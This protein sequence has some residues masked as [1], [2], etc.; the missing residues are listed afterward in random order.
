MTRLSEESLRY[1]EKR[2]AFSR[3][4]ETPFERILMVGA[5]ASIWSLHVGF[6]TIGALTLAAVAFSIL[7]FPAFVWAFRVARKNVKYVSGLMGPNK[8]VFN[9]AFTVATSLGILGANIGMIANRYVVAEIQEVLSAR[10]TYTGRVVGPKVWGWDAELE[11][12]DRRTHY[13]MVS[14]ESYDFFRHTQVVDVTVKRGLLGF[15]NIIGVKARPGAQPTV[16]ADAPTSG[17]PLN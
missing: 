4:Y 1:F 11:F 10:V 13:M 3:Q 5:L 14:R 17:A 2:K 12:P 7:F 9:F 16:P 6:E 15:D 8:R